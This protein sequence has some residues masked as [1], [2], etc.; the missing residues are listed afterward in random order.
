MSIY[1]YRGFRVALAAENDKFGSVF[2]KVSLVLFE[3]FACK[4]RRN[5]FSKIIPT[6]RVA[7]ILGKTDGKSFKRRND[8]YISSLFVTSTRCSS[9][10]FPGLFQPFL[11]ASSAHTQTAPGPPASMTHLAVHSRQARLAPI[12]TRTHTTTD[13]R[14]EHGGS[15]REL[16]HGA[17]AGCWAV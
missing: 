12:F 7:V 16:A 11:T 13:H 2:Q 17:D 8:R 9:R 14:R 15:K 3:C 4:K 5:S 6:V 10:K 1:Y